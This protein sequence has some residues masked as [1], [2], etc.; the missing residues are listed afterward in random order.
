M[1]KFSYELFITEKWFPGPTV[2]MPGV[3]LLV[4]PLGY[5]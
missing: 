2:E 3:V 4:W 1:D 5:F